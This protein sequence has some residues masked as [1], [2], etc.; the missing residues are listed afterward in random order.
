MN[1]YLCWKCNWEDF[2]HTS[3]RVYANGEYKQS[4]YATIDDHEFKALEHAGPEVWQLIQY[5]RNRVSEL[6][7]IINKNMK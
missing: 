5:L 1:T 2:Y 4:Q 7:T 3:F 6:E